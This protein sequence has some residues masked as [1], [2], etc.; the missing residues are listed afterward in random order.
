MGTVRNTQV[1][2]ENVTIFE[3][4]ANCRVEIGATSGVVTLQVDIGG[5]YFNTDTTIAN[6]TFKVVE[7]VSQA[8]NIKVTGG[9]AIIRYWN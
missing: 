7:A 3:V 4:P 8:T 2:T 5:T 9:N 1:M 6:G